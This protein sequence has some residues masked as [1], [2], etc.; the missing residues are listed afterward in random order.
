MIY[1]GTGLVAFWL[2][3]Q[4]AEESYA[5]PVF[6]LIVAVAAILVRLMRL[7]FDVIFLG[8]VLFG[9]IVGNRGFAQLM[10][11]PSLP[12][13][14]AEAALLV[15][16]G[17]W[18]VSAAF[19]RRLPWPSDFLS[20]TVLLWI[21]VGTARLL[22]DLRPYGFLAI[23][24]YAMVYYAAFYFIARHQAEQP[25][26]RRYLIGCLLLGLILILPGSLLFDAFPGFFL[27]KLTL[28]GTPLV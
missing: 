8:L 25:A 20:W 18:L 5:W 13:L 24:D 16:G 17:W 15:A 2:A 28:R 21:G 27:T 9:Y 11:A 4:L 22:F 23:R 19:A 12:L 26:A 6:A 10:P 1:S 7:S 3:W 14:P